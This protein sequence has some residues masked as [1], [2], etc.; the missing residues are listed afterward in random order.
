MSLLADISHQARARG[1]PCILCG[2]HAVIVHGFP[3]TTFDF[4][5]IIRRSDRAGWLSLLLDFGYKIYQENPGF[6]Q[7]NGPD[8]KSPPVDLMFVNED[9]FRK[10]AAEAIQAPDVVFEAS[11]ISLRHLLAM[12]CHAI[13][14]GRRGR[15]ERDM[16]DVLE[17][18]RINNVDVGRP[19]WKELI[20]KYG[21]PELYDKLERISKR[22]RS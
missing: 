7:M 13:K 17:L 15:I 2:G 9:T 8:K 10:L 1:L 12:K 16:D 20:M 6:L 21:P 18:V 11:V 4:D 3:R 5:F 14:D 22:R 19:E